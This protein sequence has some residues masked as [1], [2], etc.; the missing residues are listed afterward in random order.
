MNSTLN[1]ITNRLR[2]RDLHHTLGRFK[3]F[4]DAYSLYQNG[5]QQL[6]SNYHRAQLHPLEIS[7]FS[8]MSP[9]EHADNLRATGVSFG[10]SLPPAEDE[11]IYRFACETPCTEP[12]FAGKFYADQVSSGRLNGERHV[13]RGLVNNPENCPVVA[14]LAQETKLLQIVRSYLKYWPSQLTYHLSWSF[15]VDLSEAEQMKRYPPLN[16]HYDVAG[17]N[18]MTTYF[19]ITDIDTD[20][21]PHVM[22]E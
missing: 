6:R 22:I 7:A 2:S 11:Q 20:N 15:A 13:F 19:Y 17:Y 16:Y 21:G 8:E 5:R 4:R 1:R 14:S 12:A 18:F 10:F 9:Q 3:Q